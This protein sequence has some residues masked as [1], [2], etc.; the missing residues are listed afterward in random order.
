[1]VKQAE[2]LVYAI[3]TLRGDVVGADDL[4][5]HLENSPDFNFP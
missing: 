2:D 3:N 1:M 4:L 5:D